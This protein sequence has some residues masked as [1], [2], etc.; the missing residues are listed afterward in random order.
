MKL[1]EAKTA[2]IEA[3]GGNLTYYEREVFREMTRLSGW[4]DQ[5]HLECSQFI[6][7]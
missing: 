7:G 5:V 6:S 2:Y 1:A 3:V 4:Q